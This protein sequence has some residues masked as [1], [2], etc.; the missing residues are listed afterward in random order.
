[1]P[2]GFALATRLEQIDSDGTPKRDPQRWSSA[3]PEQPVAS[4]GDYLRVL[5]SAPSGDYRVIVF[6]VSNR[7]FATGGAAATNAQAQAWV[8]GGAEHLP[9]TVRRQRL[10]GDTHASALIYQFRK[11]GVSDPAVTLQSSDAPASRQLERTGI[12]A[13][14]RR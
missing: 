7:T 5:F 9:L 6:V 11:R 2:G 14:L 12:T 1:V 13:A 3:M 10:D 8:G 4:L